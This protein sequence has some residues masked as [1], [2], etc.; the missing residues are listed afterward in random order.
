MSTQ[1][2]EALKQQ[3]G[4]SDEQLNELKDAF[5]L[6]DENGDGGISPTEIAVVMRSLGLLYAL[7]FAWGLVARM[8]YHANMHHILKHKTGL[9]ASQ[10]EIEGMIQQF[11]EDG[12]GEIEFPE[13]ANMM[14]SKLKELNQE[15]VIEDVFSVFDEGNN[16]TNT[17]MVTRSS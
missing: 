8:P 17:G 16:N 3:L 5:A 11:D 6:F 13:F 14:S 1:E 9:D 4:L 2:D 12:N 15:S 7:C 10:E